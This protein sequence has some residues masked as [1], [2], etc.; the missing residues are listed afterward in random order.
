MDPDLILPHP[1]SSFLLPQKVDRHF[2]PKKVPLPADDAMTLGNEVTRE[3]KGGGGE[4]AIDGAD[5]LC[6][7]CM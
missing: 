1:S 7:D 6:H 5:R 4:A 2:C 3:L